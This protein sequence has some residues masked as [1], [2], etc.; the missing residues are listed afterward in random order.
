[1]KF[2]KIFSL[3]VMGHLFFLGVLFLQPGCQSI[4]QRWDE[5]R[6]QQEEVRIPPEVTRTEGGPE[7]ATLPRRISSD[8]NEPAPGFASRDGRTRARSQPLRPAARTSADDA[9]REDLFV[10]ADTWDTGDFDR[11]FNEREEVVVVET[12]P[13]AGYEPY[14]V[15]RGD[16][17]WGL[18]KR[19]SV[20]F[21]ALLEANG[22]DR[23]T[24]LRVGQEIR[25]PTG[26]S[27]IEIA[28]TAR[29]TP[30][31]AEGTTIYEVRRGDTL[32]EIAARS[33]TSVSRIR[34]LNNMSG[35]MIRV[36]QRLI[37][38]GEIPD[39]DPPR[40]TARTETRTRTTDVDDSRFTGTHTVRQGETP[41]G[42]AS[43]YNMTVDELMAANNISDPR[44]LRA[45]TE[46]RVA[47]RQAASS[48]AKLEPLPPPQTTRTTTPTP[49]T[50]ETDRADVATTPSAP[51]IV[52]EVRVIDPD[53]FNEENGFGLE[54]FDDFELLEEVPAERR[55]AG[56]N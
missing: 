23:N 50:R 32:S 42:I 22:M 55:E 5:H 17:L 35:D 29:R 26:Y 10:E 1:M 48:T 43:R 8:F 39:R 9:P 46:L 27:E 25:V 6:M 20:P 14:T 52:P 54:I 53:P 15:A 33:G 2:L 16:T 31:P 34:D 24:Q 38:P 13:D 3:V 7:A 37:V 30:Q 51:E 47:S 45:G 12:S 41:G 4:D 49:R 36:G 44:R 28:D 18:S 19:F 21:A 11:S 40:S 56:S